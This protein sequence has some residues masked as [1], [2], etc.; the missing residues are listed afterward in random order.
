[1]QILHRKIW[2]RGKV[3]GVYFRASTKTKADLLGVKGSVRNE[4]DGSVF[5]ECEATE[6]TLNQFIEWCKK[7]PPHARVDE[8]QVLE[9]EL[10]HF[11]SFRIN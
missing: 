4:S 11:T 8:V 10:Q 1:M 7:G 9:G 3:Q 2:V 5:M 6:N